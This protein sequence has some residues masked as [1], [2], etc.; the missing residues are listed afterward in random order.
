MNV[1]ING[2]SRDVAPDA[3]VGDLLETLGVP[4]A[5]VAVARNARVVA[6]AELAAEPIAAGDAIE[7]I[8]AVSGG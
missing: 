6:R 2:E 7:I 3:T 8:R 5:G 4:L 1:T